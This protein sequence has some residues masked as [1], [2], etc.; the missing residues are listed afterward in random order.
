MSFKKTIT[1]VVAVLMMSALACNF[2]A[3][4]EPTITPLPTTTPVP[5]QTP[6]ATFTPPPTNTPT[7]TPAP[8][9]TPRPT[10]TPTPIPQPGAV[11]LSDT[12]ETEANQ[13]GILTGAKSSLKINNGELSFQ[14]RDRNVFYFTNPTGK[15]TD[16]DLTFEATLAEGTNANSMFGGQC[17]KRDDS[18][19]YL[20]A[21][22][23]NGFYTVTKY[24]NDDWQ[25]L[26]EWTK[27]SAIKTGKATNT[28]RLICA[29]EALQLWV[30]GVRLVTLKDSAFKTGQIGVVVGTF[31]ETSPNTRVV[32]DN[33]SATFP[34]PV[35]LATGGGSGTGGSTNTPTAAT[36]SPATQPVVVNGQGTLQIENTIQFGVQFVLW[37]PSNQRIN[38]PAGQT[39]TVQLPAGEYGW[40]V[41]A[42]GCELYPTGNLV[43]NPSANIL[44]ETYTENSCGYQVR[45]SYP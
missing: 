22:T 11:L 1:L 32:F 6:T 10:A 20:F 8:T 40:Q 33:L 19:F 4:P 13:W 14:V 18:N 42:N 23:G 34:E 44:V 45:W 5:S 39:I 7:A 24:I 38:S 37:G 26:V 27:S 9:R 16:V 28:L 15:F 12:F 2:S 43:V 3:T 35:T 21:L 31:D 30:N 41:F 25:P 29:G 17:R 36:V